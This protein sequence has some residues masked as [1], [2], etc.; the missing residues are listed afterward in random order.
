[1]KG[2][3]LKLLI[4]FL[5]VFMVLSACA[6]AAPQQPAAQQPAAQQP[7]AAEDVIKVGWIGALTGDSA[8]YGTA[9]RNGALM[10][11]DKINAEGGV[12]GKKLQLIDYDDKGDQLEAVNVAKRLIQEDKVVA[13][14]G[15]NGSGRNIAV[16]PVFEEA[17]IPIIATYATNPR[18]TQPTPDT[19]NKYTFRVCFTDPYQGQVMADFA[20]GDLKAKK[21]AVVFEISS[22]YSVGL[23]DFFKKRWLELGGDLVAEEAFKAG[24]VEFRAQLTKIKE[25]NP[26]VIAMPFVTYKDVALFAKQARDLGIT[27]TMIG[28]DG[29]P[30]LELLKMAAPAVEG[31]YFVDHTD[32]NMDSVKEWREQY[33]QRFG[34]DMEVNT[35]MIH[36]SLL[37]LK[38]AIEKAGSTD[39]VKIA[40]A[41]TSMDPVEGFTGSIKLDPATHNPVGKSAVIIAIK[42]GK[43]SLFKVVAPMK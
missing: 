35:I 7:A 3:W 1:M 41:L 22:D 31:S 29:W 28:S 18:V 11:I 17:K 38:G 32:V 25:A 23:K 9:E 30:S 4:S 36:D 21:A 8:V 10:M 15:T 13:V 33:K 6:P 24:D 34:K 19:L 2:I 43:F 14:L 27:A 5:L 26:D 42:D 37:L 12:L 16:A 20:Y 40:E 39:P